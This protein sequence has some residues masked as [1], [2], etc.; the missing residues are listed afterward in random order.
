[1]L[2]NYLAAALGDLARNRVYAAISI[3]GLAV[4]IA[5]A[6]LTAVLLRNHFSYEHFISNHD[7]TYVVLSAMLPTGGEPRYS[8]HTS[9]LVAGLLRQRFPEVTASTRLAEQNVKLRG[10]GEDVKEQVYWADANAFTVLQLPVYAGDLN[11]AL[12][13][14]DGIVL[15]RSKARKYFGSEDALGRS[16][17]LDAVHPMTVSA[18]IEDLP[19]NG[20]MLTNDI[21]ASGRASFS[22]LAR[23]DADPANRVGSEAFRINVRTYLRMPPTVSVDQLNRGMPTLMQT[24]WPQGAAAFNASMPVMRIDQE[25]LFEPMN[26]GIGSRIAITGV[27]GMLILFLA[28]ANFVNLTTARSARRALEVG[29]RKATG[30]SRA[31]LIVQFLGESAMYVVVAMCLGVAITELAL[32]HLNAFLNSGAEFAYWRDPML[33]TMLIAG[34]LVLT[35]AA[36]LYPAFVV[37]AFRPAQALRGL[38]SHSL[39]PN[40]V[41]QAL[42]ILQFAVLIGLVIAAGVL[43]R[44]RWFATTE[45]LRVDVDQVLTIESDCKAVLRD[46]LQRIPGVVS[47][48]CA[49][50]ALFNNSRFSSIELADGTPMSITDTPVS[51][52]MFELL[53]LK[54]LAGRFFAEG[55]DDPD[56]AAP[57]A[58]SKRCVINEAAARR[59][60][61]NSTDQALGKDIPSYGEVI[62]VVPDFSL[63]SV[64]QPIQPTIYTQQSK[65]FDRINLKLS[66]RNIPEALAAIDALWTRTG[67][68]AGIKRY[69]VDDH[70]QSLYLGMLREAQALNVFAGV[71]VLLACLG[72][73][74]LSAST[75]EQRSKEIAV[76][77]AMGA[78]SLEIFRFLLWKFSVPVGWAALL[79]WP[80]TAYLMNRW[81]SRFAYHVTLE[82]WWFVAAAAG[83]LLIAGLTVA[84]HCLRVARTKPALALRAE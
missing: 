78:G 40:T 16:L 56:T 22:K 5:A 84:T 69:F 52:G 73:F 6:L 12:L 24:L 54:P 2:G 17:L 76:R 80:L 65:M 70:L 46:E 68:T 61:W 75:T 74:A 79:A 20:T 15:S 28:C 67:N 27:A 57:A 30:A 51:A 33:I 4:G 47:V 44:Q 14:P 13:R 35:L 71:A 10:A 41:R 25:H 38:V 50:D 8:S 19:Q 7:E 21:F 23:I 82:P 49:S 34:T 64:E 9:S 83:A 32:P 18:V 43:Q 45:A 53:G 62:G 31:A 66:G 29:V 37:S 26:R 1:M 42:V 11:S 59:L 36:G 81:L 77:K 3:F 63:S 55:R 72:L 48:A 58:T 39:R 60:G